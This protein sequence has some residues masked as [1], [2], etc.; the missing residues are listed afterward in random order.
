MIHSMTGFA[1]QTREVGG[2]SIHLELRSVNSRYLDLFF[3]IGDELRQ[4]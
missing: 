2:A 4:A 3:R 1:A